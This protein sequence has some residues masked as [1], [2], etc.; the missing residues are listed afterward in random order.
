M[1]E[2]SHK[3]TG[4]LFPALLLVFLGLYLAGITAGVEP[5]IAMLR[6]GLASVTLAIVGRFV[7]G[8]LDNL[9]EPVRVE[10]ED[11]AQPA[12]AHSTPIRDEE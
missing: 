3:L 5:E 12:D 7:S 1:S 2:P 4:L 10:D 9:P 6:A 8:M 11:S